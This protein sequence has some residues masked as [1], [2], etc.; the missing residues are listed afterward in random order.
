MGYKFKIKCNTQKEYENIKFYFDSVGISYK[1]KDGKSLKVDCCK[2]EIDMCCTM[3]GIHPVS[4]KAC[5]GNEHPEAILGYRAVNKADGFGLVEKY[6]MVSNIN[7]MLPSEGIHCA[8]D[9][10]TYE[11]VMH[12][13]DPS[14]LTKEVFEHSNR[15][16]VDNFDEYEIY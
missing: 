16:F 1:Q 8:D 9:I 3:L 6:D 7:K 15:S 14:G 10:K 4:V 12:A 13:M 11:S 2:N 5:K